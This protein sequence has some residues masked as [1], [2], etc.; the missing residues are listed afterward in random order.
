MSTEADKL[1]KLKK[2]WEVA[3]ENSLTSYRIDGNPNYVDAMLEMRNSMRRKHSQLIE[4]SASMQS[5]N[6]YEY[7]L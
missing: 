4:K 2:T 7:R 6:W 1:G 5:R 3:A